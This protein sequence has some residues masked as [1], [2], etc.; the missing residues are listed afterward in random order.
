LVD[1]SIKSSNSNNLASSSAFK[2]NINFDGLDLVREIL[3]ETP[4]FPCFVL[5]SFDDEA[6]ILLFVQIKGEVLAVIFC[7]HLII[8]RC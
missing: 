1:F 6:V 2:S 4:Q 3:N 7:Y 8:S 5:T